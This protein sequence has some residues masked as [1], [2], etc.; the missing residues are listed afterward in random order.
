MAATPKPLP[1]RWISTL[2]L[3]LLSLQSALAEAEQDKTATEAKPSRLAQYYGFGPM[4]I[5]KLQWKLGQPIIADINADGLNDLIFINNRKARIDLLLQKKDFDPSEYVPIDILDEDVNDIFGR[6]KSWRFKRF[7]YDLDVEATSLV[8]ADLNAD[9]RLDLAFYAKDALRV[10]LQDEPK[11]QPAEEAKG[12]EAEDKRPSGP[13][14]PVWMPAKKIDIREGLSTS[15]ALAAGDLN[16]D[17]RADLALLAAEGTFVLMQKSDGTLAQ[18]EKFYSAGQK[19]KQ[20][21]IAD[22]NGDK[23]LD[24]VVITA[25]KEFPVRL[26]YQSNTGKLGPEVRYDLPSPRVLEIASLAQSPQSY[27]LCVNRLSGRI[28]ISTLAPNTRREEFPVFTYPLPATESPENRDIVAADVDGDGLEDVVVS[29]PSGEFLLF[30]GAAVAG[31]TGPQRFPG[32]TDMR[33]LVAGDLD[34]SGKQAIV[35]L[36]IEEKIIAISRMTDGRLSFPESVSIADEPLAMDLADINGD[37]QLDLLYIARQK[38]EKKYFYFLRTVLSVGRDNAQPGPELELTELKDKPQDLRAGDIDHDSRPDV[39]VLRP[40]GPLL[41]LRQSQPGEFSQVTKPDIYSGLVADVQP[42]S[43]SLSPLGPQGGTAVLLAKKN[44]ARAVVFDPAK[45]WQ[46]VDQYQA[47][48]RQSNL[49]AAVACLLPGDEALAVVV[50]DAARAKLEI[51]TQQPDGTYRT[52]R[53][54]KIGS[55]S[56]KKMLTGNFGGPSPLSILLAGTHK[57]ILLPVAGQTHLL[58]KLASFESDIKKVRYGAMAVGDINADDL[59]EI[60]VIDQAHNRLEIL[61]FDGAG[62]LTS[63]SK[64]KVFEEP[65]AGRSKSREPRIVLLGDLTADGKNDLILVVHDRIIIYPQD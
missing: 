58:Q 46:V 10:V 16:S 2:A 48:D 39:M 52:D 27:F 65:R 7:S 63:A 59:P 54:I 38:K 14:E 3:C 56:A 62:E 45:G 24:L 26:R 40:Y 28:Q 11:P 19:P 35:A 47:S 34:G 30:R 15:R 20:L 8:L 31:L 18:P 1:I 22:V 6:E 9:D 25:E 32:L 50:Y 44:F 12:A 51:L 33:K 57:M 21:H 60:V 13:R 4:E 43:L 23:R 29:D 17:G 37:G 55:V 49:T 61:T 41:L 64:F 36:S 42:S 53:D 5:L